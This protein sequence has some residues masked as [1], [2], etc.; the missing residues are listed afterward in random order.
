MLALS[1]LCDEF[2]RE[3]LYFRS[4]PVLSWKKNADLGVLPG[5]FRYSSNQATLRLM[6]SLRWSGFTNMWPSRS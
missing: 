3:L 4:A 2:A 6:T 5:Y 1:A